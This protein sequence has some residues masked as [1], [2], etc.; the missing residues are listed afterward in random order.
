MWLDTSST[1]GVKKAITDRYLFAAFVM[2]H[3]FC[4]LH[5]LFRIRKGEILPWLL[6][7]ALSKCPRNCPQRFAEFAEFAKYIH[8]LK[9]KRQAWCTKKSLFLVN[10]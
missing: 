10:Y 8:E 1:S 9:K 6:P 7:A 5:N 3:W 2:K 4:V